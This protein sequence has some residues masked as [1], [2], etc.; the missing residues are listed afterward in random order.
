MMDLFFYISTLGKRNN[1]LNA[2]FREQS[3]QTPDANMISEH[4]MIILSHKMSQRGQNEAIVP[5][6][7]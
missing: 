3:L 4:N 6:C 1:L 2:V 5:K 7:S